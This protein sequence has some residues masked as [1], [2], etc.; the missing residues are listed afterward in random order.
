MNTIHNKEGSKI[1]FTTDSVAVNS[2]V[3]TN[4][5]PV[6]LL[7]II[8]IIIIGIVYLIKRKR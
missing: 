8:V 4:F 2:G 1:L 3:L 6:I 7:S 5:L